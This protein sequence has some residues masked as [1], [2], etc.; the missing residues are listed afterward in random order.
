[1]NRFDYRRQSRITMINEGLNRTIFN[2]RDHSHSF[3][4]KKSEEIV[5]MKT[6]KND[7]I[8]KTEQS[9]SPKHFN[10]NRPVYKFNK[11]NPRQTENCTFNIKNSLNHPNQ[12]KKYHLAYFK[13][14]KDKIHKLEGSHN[15]KNIESSMNNN[16]LKHRHKKSKYLFHLIIP[17][18][19]QWLGICSLCAIDLLRNGVEVKEFDQEYE[20]GERER[21]MTKRIQTEL[22]NTNQEIK[23]FEQMIFDSE[24]KFNRDKSNILSFFDDLIS[25]VSAQKEKWSLYMNSCYIDKKRELEL[26]KSKLQSHRDRLINYN[27]RPSAL[28]SAI[29]KNEEIENICINFPTIPSPRVF[30][31]IQPFNVTHKVNQIS[32][33]IEE[34]ISKSMDDNLR[35]RYFDLKDDLSN[36]NSTNKN[37]RKIDNVSSIEEIHFNKSKNNSCYFTFDI[38]PCVL[39]DPMIDDK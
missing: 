15:S 21:K 1:M 34:I 38:D 16:C 13:D 2:L 39:S 29:N 35:I 4:R 20:R 5:K 18:H 33:M 36:K 8:L 11:N 24:K 32:T 23:K 6:L 12:A 27:N 9:K 19:T 26:S 14:I 7:V 28:S 31:F 10:K 30:H 25:S 3:K 22:K 37:K 17:G